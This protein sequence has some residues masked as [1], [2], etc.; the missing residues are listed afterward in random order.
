[1]TPAEIIRD[2]HQH[3]GKVRIEGANLALTAPQPLPA[4]LIK[5]LRAHKREL[6][7][8]L[9]GDTIADPTD[10]CP[11]CGSGRWWQ[12]PGQPW[13]CRACEADMPREATTLTLPCQRR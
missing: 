11:A 13:H 6:L 12:L 9:R 3:R 1:M 4:E 5:E 8:H 7:A 2:I 10:P